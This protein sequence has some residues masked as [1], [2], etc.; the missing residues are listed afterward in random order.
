MAERGTN[1]YYPPDFDPKL[2][3][4][5]NGYQGVHHLRE[6]AR[7]IDQGIIIIRFEMPF[8]VWCLSCNNHIA[9]GVRYNAQ[10]SKVGKY[11]T[12]TIYKFRMK[13][14]LCDNYFEIQ[15][16]PK[17]LDYEMISG[18]RRQERRWDPK[19]NQQITPLDT[20]QANKKASNPMFKLEYE[21]ADRKKL[22]EK[23]P[24]LE[25]IQQTNQ[26][27][28]DDYAWNSR[29]RH[30]LRIKRKETKLRQEK[31]NA[32]LKKSSLSIKLLPE[33]DKDVKIASL[34]KLSQVKAIRKEIM[35]GSLL[36]QD[37]PSSSQQLNKMVQ[38]R[39]AEQCSRSCVRSRTRQSLTPFHELSSKLKEDCKE[40]SSTS[41]LEALSSYQSSDD[42]EEK[43]DN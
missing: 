37:N 29:L 22:Q 27:M 8:N 39:K 9:M 34:M 19:D 38:E 7:K 41:G 18:C 42:E 33:D 36:T 25:R 5:A 21:A 11:Y 30:D 16:D 28:K 31:D 1:F 6:R 3:G 17:N 14:H 35:S 10:K 2:H 32:L 15:T 24:V 12:T 40:I 13:C 26:R 20:D 23:I 43:D 4:S